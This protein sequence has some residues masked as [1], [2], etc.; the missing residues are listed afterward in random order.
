MRGFAARTISDGHA[1]SYDGAHSL[2]SYARCAGASSRPAEVRSSRNV[3]ATNEH[4]TGLCLLTLEGCRSVAKAGNMRRSWLRVAAALALV[5]CLTIGNA[6]GQS[7]RREAERS[8]LLVGKAA[9]PEQLSEQAF[10]ETLAR[11]YN[12]V[13]PEDAMKWWVVRPDAATFN[14]GPADRLVD[15]ARLHGMKVRGHTLVWDH[16]NPKWLGERKWTPQELSSV[17][18]DHSLREGGAFSGSGVRVGCGQ[19]SVRRTWP[20]E[21][22][23]LVRAA[24]DRFRR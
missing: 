11:E 23:D 20:P 13:E 22:V 17:L 1:L 5:L 7:L 3:Q 21:I 16:S 6:R 8:G 10:A 9:R 15:F 24:G 19:R 12:T 14:F 4:H 18:Q 2:R